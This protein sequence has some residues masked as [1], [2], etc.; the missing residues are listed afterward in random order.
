VTT[1]R[2]SELRLLSKLALVIILLIAAGM[3]W[4]GVTLDVFGRIQLLHF[5]PNEAVALALALAFQPYVIVRGLVTR[6]HPHRQA[7]R[8]P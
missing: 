2:P 5:Y 3:P 1:V 6:F 8:Q 4:H 7:R